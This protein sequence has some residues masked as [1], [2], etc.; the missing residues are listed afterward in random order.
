MRTKLLLIMSFFCTW[1]FS[2][3][4]FEKGY[5]IDDKDVITECLIKNLDW[6]SNP[7]SFEYKISEA[8][9]AQTATIKG[10]KQFEIYNG[11]KFVRYEV[12]IDR[13]ST[14]LNK[15]SRKKNPEFVKETVFL[16]EL[17][18]GK[19]KLYKFTEGNFTKYFYQNSDA[20]PEQLI[21]KQY[22]VGE[23]D[24]TYN[25]DYISQLQN[26]FTCSSISNSDI[27]KL[28]YKEKDLTNFFVNYNH[29]ADPNFKLAVQNETKP[30]FNLNI[31]PRINFSSLEIFSGNTMKTYPLGNKTTFA[32]GLEA[33]YLLAFN[34][35]KFAIIVEPTYQYYKSEAT[36]DDSSLIGGKVIVK[37]DYSSIELPIGIRY[38]MY[39][40]TDSKLFVNAVYIIDFSLGKS[41]EM[42]R[43][44]GSPY[45]SYD[46]RSQPSLGFGIGYK[47]KDKYGI[48][49]RTHSKRRITSDY[50]MTSTNY[51]TTSVVFSYNLF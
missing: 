43:A 30:K 19:G 31:R 20:A 26:N 25:K 10:V 24:M 7:N 51:Q 44:D 23:T 38:Y 17:V 47:Y 5:F 37:A 34:K 9:K 46:L 33:E 45:L 41:I 15:L 40:N 49:L 3:I 14:D 36:F 2:Q 13:S 16:K 35:N 27:S 1:A 22:Q 32:I 48:E 4:K 18:N 11:A 21:Y 42:T 29:C 50:L 6:K 12:N 28:E 8:D 39:L